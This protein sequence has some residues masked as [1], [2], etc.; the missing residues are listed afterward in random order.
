MAK[1]KDVKT[2]KYLAVMV[3]LLLLIILSFAYF[4]VGGNKIA[5]IYSIASLDEIVKFRV[6]FALIGILLGVL[7][8]GTMLWHIIIADSMKLKEYDRNIARIMYI[9]TMFFAMILVG[10]GTYTVSYNYQ[11]SDTQEVKR[12]IYTSRIVIKEGKSLLEPNKVIDS[13]ILNDE[14][15]NTIKYSPYKNITMLAI[16]LAT[17]GKEVETKLEEEIVYMKTK[18]ILKQKIIVVNDVYNEF[19]EY[20]NLKEQED[21][22]KNE[23]KEKI[24]EQKRYD[25]LK[26]RYELGVSCGCSPCE[27]EAVSNSNCVC[28]NSKDICTTETTKSCCCD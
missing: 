27:C 15:Q 10:F 3:V 11:K 18:D 14:Y 5:E 7:L 19:V 28:E 6:R 17:N 23:E 9:I 2:K 1:K 16:Y 21:R 22:K 25:W 20:M 26:K 8:F 13:R 4:I 12:K 24:A